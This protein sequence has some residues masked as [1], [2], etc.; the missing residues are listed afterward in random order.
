MMPERG[1]PWPQQLSSATSFCC[2]FICLLLH[3]GITILCIPFAFLSC[4]VTRAEPVRAEQAEVTFLV[5]NREMFSYR[6]TGH[7]QKVADEGR[8][9]AVSA[10]GML[11]LAQVCMFCSQAGGAEQPS[12]AQAEQVTMYGNSAM[13]PALAPM[14][15]LILSAS[16]ALL[17][18]STSQLICHTSVLC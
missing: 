6:T 7:L 15:S 16:H 8:S 14:H 13:F 3:G 12:T 1:W 5:S 17:S 10:A 2:H 4:K 11:D 18:V 9:Q